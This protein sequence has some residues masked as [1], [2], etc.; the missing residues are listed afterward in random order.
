MAWG[1]APV[2]QPPAPVAKRAAVQQKVVIRED[3]V[4][5]D[6]ETYYDDDYT[7]RKL[8]YSEYI[9]DPQFE[10]I[11]C[12]VKVGSG[13][14]IVHDEGSLRNKLKKIDWSK[15]DLLCHNTPF[16]GFI[17]SHHYGV[18]PRKY[19]DTLAMARGLFGND[20]RA[21]LDTLSNYLG[22]R[23][24][25][26]G[27]LEDVKGLHAEEIRYGT[28]GLCETMLWQ[29]L[30]DYCAQ[31]VDEMVDAFYK[32]TAMLPPLEFDKID[33]FIRAFC[34]PVLDVD[35]KRVEK[36]LTR[37]IEEKE[38][39]LLT[40]VGTKPEQA[41]LILLLGRTEA[42]EHAK[43]EI[44]SSPR[45]AELLEGL[46]VKPPMKDGKNGP[47][48]AFAKTD[49]DFLALLEHPEKQ[50]RNLCE[51]RLEV[52]STGNTAKAAR[53]LKISE[54]GCKLPI[55]L[56][57][58]AAHTGRPG[59]GN[60]MN[61][62]NLERGG[63]LRKSILAP[64][65]MKMCL[66]DS[67]QIEARVA[68]WISGQMDALEEFA[69]ADRG[70]DRDPYCKFADDVYGYKVI[71]EKHPDERHVGKVAKLQLQ[72]QAGPPRFQSSMALGALGGK[73]MFIELEEAQR[74]VW[75]FRRK[76]DKIVAFWRMC[77]D[78]IIPDMIAGRSGN[79]KCLHWEKE[80]I[81]LPNGMCL[82]YPGLRKIVGEEETYYMYE[83]K[84][85]YEKIYGG[86]LTE[87]IVQALANVIVT[88]QMTQIAA[89]YR[90]VSMTYDEN[91]WI[92]PSKEAKKAFEFGLA[93][94]KTSPAWCQDLPLFAEGGY[95]DNYSKK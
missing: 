59:G 4:S 14:T 26:K 60:K 39:K 70:E 42:L 91:V 28:A 67:G 37:E 85:E 81:W 53:F 2:P 43:K 7:L 34:D 78:R 52:K 41:K 69:V 50:V 66:A 83:R 5:L 92:A 9:R 33:I 27:A 77:N 88:E 47:I 16:D 79:W 90:I 64:K 38:K 65:G 11:M 25:M 30:T 84:G 23:G 94:M 61:M 63:E 48:F 46:G 15:H 68:M 76:H 35:R 93:I 45:F 8:S 80:R 87:N 12:G 72:Y 20:I 86:L 32:M 18:V 40:A 13:P 75:L 58:Y 55:L 54:N 10:V 57:Y 24:K 21:D 62:L 6:F 36:E 71:K 95:A 22:G 1:R 82:K 44:G 17:L 49:E 74:I 73:P 29:K 31:D 56:N 51:A 3:L 89:K 19:F